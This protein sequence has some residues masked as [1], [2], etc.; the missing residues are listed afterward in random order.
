MAA[1][2]N[3]RNKSVAAFLVYNYGQE[4]F[5]HAELYEGS[6]FF[7]F[8][9]DRNEPDLRAFYDAFEQVGKLIKELKPYEQPSPLQTRS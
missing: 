1:L 7:Y 5:D 2:Y 4:S 8:K 9:I 3:T 6:V